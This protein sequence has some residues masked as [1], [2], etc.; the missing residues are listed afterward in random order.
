MVKGTLVNPFDEE[1]RDVG[2]WI[3]SFGSYTGNRPLARSISL[4]ISR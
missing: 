4:Q 3:F 2:G 1:P